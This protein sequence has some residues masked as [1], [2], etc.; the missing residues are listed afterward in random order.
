MPRVL[1]LALALLFVA[2]CVGP[3]PQPRPPPGADA[4][5]T[6]A[7]REMAAR[8]YREILAMLAERGRLDED[9]A[10]LDRSRRISNGLVA[11]AAQLRPE[12]ATWS[13]E[14]HVTG[15]PSRAT[16]CIAGGKILVSAEQVA[17][18]GLRDGELAM[19]LAHEIAHAVADHRREIARGGVDA[20]VAQEVRATAIAIAQEDEAD[21]IGMTLARLAGWPADELAGLYDKLAAME[22]AGTS[23]TSHASAVERAARARSLAASPGRQ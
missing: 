21:R 18:L 14:I 11:A 16:F 15:E 9:R 2:A 5:L 4:P 22:G 23:S 10:L 8:R 13:W 1:L 12:T 20:D 19:L 6:E 17:R 7:F 3:Q